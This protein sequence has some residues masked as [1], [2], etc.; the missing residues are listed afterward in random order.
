MTELYKRYDK[1]DHS[2]VSLWSIGWVEE[3]D[4]MKTFWRV[5]EG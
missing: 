5:S 1:K 2:F 3:S 4:G